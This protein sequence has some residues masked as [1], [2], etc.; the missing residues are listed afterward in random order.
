MAHDAKTLKLTGVFNTTPDSSGASFWNGGGGPAADKEGDVYVVSA[1]GDFDGNLNGA[2]YDESVLKLTAASGLTP[3]D[4]FTPFNKV[5]LDAADLDVGSSSAVLLPDEAG[6]KD[7]PHVLF[8]SGK[9]GRMYLLDAD[10]LGGV[11]TGTDAGA[12][13]SIP[14]VGLHPTFGSAAYFN[15]T[16]YVAPEDSPMFA[17]PV[18]N[19]SLFSD[20]STQTL[21][22]NGVHGGIPSISANGNASGVVWLAT[23]DSGGRLLA[24]DASDLSELY[25]SNLVP[26]DR[27]GAPIEFSVP[28]IADGK[29]FVATGNSVAVYGKLAAG[30]PSVAAVTNAAS[31]SENALSPGSLVTLFG[32]NLSAGTFNGIADPLPLSIADTS[33]TVNGVV[34]PVLFVSPGQINAQIP[35]ETRAGPANVVV[36]AQGATSAKF[37]ITVQPAAPGLFTNLQGQAAAIN[38]DGSVNSSTH[39]AA[40]GSFV[41]IFFTGQGPVAKAVDDGATPPVGQTISATSKVSATI[42]GTPADIQFAGLSP[43]FPGVAQI[44]VKIP[45][46]SNGV[47]PL[48]VTI[49]GKASNSAQLVVSGN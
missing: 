22:M 9:E 39:P 2:K 27:L 21:N 32:S 46:I 25:D 31:Y 23:L 18:A 13:S 43:L 30:P 40:K 8:T 45:A 20:A 33:V 14:I 3:L 6:S 34:A 49:G 28:M 11:Q 29:V 41:S 48:I 19:A 7:H 15:G 37:N 16:V 38:A 36:R 42:G 1:N 17:F 24:Y 4:Q 10:A 5:S 12:L 26:S 35:W 44:N 47:H